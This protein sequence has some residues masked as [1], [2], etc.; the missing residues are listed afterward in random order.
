[1]SSRRVALGFFAAPPAVV[2]AIVLVAGFRT[3]PSAWPNMPEMALKFLLTAYMLTALIGV[4]V[5]LLLR[6]MR[7]QSLE[8][9]VAGTAVAALLAAWLAQ[10]AAYLLSRL[11]SDDTPFEVGL[12]S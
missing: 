8:D 11:A 12:L 4:P 2:A 6:A 5:H 10:L 9:Y 7:R 3:P 1:M